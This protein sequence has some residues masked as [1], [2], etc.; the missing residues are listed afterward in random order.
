MA[1]ELTKIEALTAIV[2]YYQGRLFE[3]AAGPLVEYELQGIPLI[4]RYH[5]LIR[6][7]SSELGVYVAAYISDIEEIFD[8]KPDSLSTDQSS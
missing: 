8:E 3:V 1:V 2:E 5:G 7:V 4:D 6:D